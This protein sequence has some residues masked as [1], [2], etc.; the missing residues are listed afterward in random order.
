ML[1]NSNN[2]ITICHVINS[3]ALIFQQWSLA[4][5]FQKSVP[6]Y[7]G[8]RKQWSLDNVLD[9]IPF[10]TASNHTGPPVIITPRQKNDEVLAKA[11]QHNQIWPNCRKQFQLTPNDSYDNEIGPESV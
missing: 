4:A 7:Q 2:V 10:Y 6:T 9:P 11:Q 1:L 8:G 5:A 3:Q